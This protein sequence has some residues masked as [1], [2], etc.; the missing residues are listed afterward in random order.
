[1]WIRTVDD[2]GRLV[3]DRRRQLGLSQAELAERVGVSR[4]WLVGLE[5]G[6]PTVEMALALRTLALLGLNLDAR[7]PRQRSDS[8]AAAAM[9]DAVQQ[10]LDHHK[11]AGERRTLRTRP[12]RKPIVEPDGFDD[13]DEQQAERPARGWQP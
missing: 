4:Q 12:P 9:I 6:K 3:K 8:G 5:R 11:P 10:V 13:P 7:D 1:M 2:V